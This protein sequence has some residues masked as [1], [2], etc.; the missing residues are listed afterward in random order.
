MKR[1][2]V[3]LLASFALVGIQACSS[4]PSH[5]STA[6]YFDDAGTTAKVK[7]ALVKVQGLDAAQINVETYRGVVSLSG[8]VD[9]ASMQQEA[10]A[11][12]K[13]VSG[14]KSVKNDMRVKPTK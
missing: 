13:N 7:T 9:S 14:V 11:A 8:F 10:V 12:A 5:E 6:E 4:T 2:L 1:L 3:I